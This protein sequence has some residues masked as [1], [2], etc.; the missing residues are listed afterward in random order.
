M[1]ALTLLHFSFLAAALVVLSADE[2][3]EGQVAKEKLPKKDTLLLPEALTLKVGDPMSLMATVLQPAPMKGAIS[4]TVET[5]LHRA[6][7]SSVSVNQDGSLFATGGYDGVIRLWDSSGKLVRALVGHNTSIASVAFSP[8]GNYLASTGGNTRIWNHKTG[9]T[10]RSLNHPKGYAG[11]ALWSPDGKTLLVAGGSSG[12]TTVWDPFANKQ[13]I[14]VEQG[15]PVSGI[16]WSSDGKFFVVGTSRNAT[17]WKTSDGSNVTT[18]FVDGNVV[19]SVAF[20]GDGKKIVTG[21][22]KTIQIW[23]ET[24]KLEKTL[25]G[26]ATVLSLSPGGDTLAAS[27]GGGCQIFD[28]KTWQKTMDLNAPAVGLDWNR[29]SGALVSLTGSEVTS[30]DLKDGGSPRSFT[31]SAGGT[32]NWTPGRPVVSG[33][34]ETKLTLWESSTGRPIQTLDGHTAA[35]N[36]FA[37]SRDGKFLATASSDKTAR[38]WDSKNGKPLRT[39]DGHGDAVN[40]VAWSL[41]G[42]L[43]TA[44]RDKMV[45]IFSP[46]DDKP[47]ITL[48]EHTHPVRAIAWSRDGRQFA[49]GGDDGK[50]FLWNLETQKP[51]QT[52]SVDKDVYGLAF[53]PD[54]RLIACGNADNMV[55]IYAVAT[56][57][58]V[59][60][61]DGKGGSI[62]SC[63]LLWSND[64]TKIVW[65]NY[66]AQYWDVKSEMILHGYQLYQF[67]T[68]STAFT[69]D[70]KGF[71][72]HC[73]DRT[74]RICDATGKVRTTLVHNAK[75]IV[76]ISTEGHF[77]AVSDF[78]ADL[79]YVIQTDKSQDTYD[80]RGL[81]GK[82]A[83]RNNSA[84]VKL[85]GN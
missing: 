42:R 82:F 4:W 44:S 64:G 6:G 69:A 39:L 81:A 84:S 52:I 21:G 75:Q 29:K 59:H 47:K 85:T 17:V 71:V 28:G 27:Y 37:W 63:E 76:A 16:A 79:I 51:I 20:S 57:K 74:A 41:D 66:A 50:L 8:D 70:G 46:D 33:L 58:V 9:M 77:R 68:Y 2:A 78:D 72:L 83:W 45:R 18:I 60:T 22:I 26:R 56:G 40:M 23:D 10:V 32:L 61:L 38:V 5:R 25:E 73:N 30:N 48:K 11:R 19:Y 24:Y 36:H 53:S 62:R 14:T 12:F 15:V 65:T 7:A 34:Y 80:V 55:R 13:L 43:A 54:G 35:V 67:Y 49:S 3:V 31:V 1:R